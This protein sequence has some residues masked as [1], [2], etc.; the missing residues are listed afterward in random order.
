M[1]TTQIELAEWTG[2]T[3][4]TIAKI[5]ERKAIPWPCDLKT[6]VQGVVQYARGE[7]ST[8]DDLDLTAER[9]RLAKEQADKHELENAKTRGELIVTEDAMKAWG[10]VVQR[11]RS[12]LLSIPSKAAPLL[13][14][15]KRTSEAK[16]T[17]EKL[18]CEALDELSNPNLQH[19]QNRASDK[20]DTKAV[21]ASPK[22]D[23]KP[24]GRPRKGAKSRK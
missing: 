24:V 10:A 16:D 4:Q 5:I 7:S 2:Y 13:I 19:G 12:R 14:G 9:A 15:I 11:V 3:R 6:G 20:G 22:A 23:S 17:I 1:D 21:Q 18:V 8:V